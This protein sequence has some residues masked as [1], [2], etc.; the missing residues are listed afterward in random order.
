[1]S[2]YAIPSHDPANTG[3]LAGTLREVFK[4]L[5]QGVD[6]ML[7]AKIVGYDRKCNVAT[8]QPQIMM[9]TTEN[10][11]LSR[12]PLAR[13][14]VLALGGGGFVMSFPLK[15]G[16]AGWIKASDRDISLYL[17]SGGEVGPNTQRL[18]SFADGLFIPDVMRGYT[19]ADEDKANAVLQSA[20]G[21]VRVA[22]WS[23]KLKLTAPMVE[24]DAANVHCTGNLTADGRVTGRGGVTFGETPAETHRHDGVQRGSDTS[25]GP[26]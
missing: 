12:P 21:L 24:L 14:P 9:L 22:L 1:M 3:G 10:R 25:G 18:H 13:V 6:D 17:Q 8:V 2:D 11:T 7:P 16:D 19:L 26:V 15:P 23:D 20:D 5:M 4:K